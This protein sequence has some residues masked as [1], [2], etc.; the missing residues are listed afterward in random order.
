MDDHE[1][2]RVGV[3]GDILNSNGELAVADTGLGPLDE[4]PG[5]AWEFIK[6]RDNIL[7]SEHIRGYDALL[8]VGRR[9][10]RETLR[11]VDR[12]AIVARYGV[13][14]DT[15]DVEACTDSGVLVT[16]TPDGVRRPVASV[17]VGFVLALS[18]DLMWKDRMT[19]EG[20]WSERYDRVG[21]GLRGR[22]LGL[23]GLGNIGSEVARLIKP[24]DMRL[25]AADPYVEPSSA[26]QLNVKLV[27]LD[28]LMTAA[29]FVCI[30]CPLNNSTRGMIDERRLGLLKQTAFLINV[31]RGPIVD[32]S[33]LTQILKNNRIRGAALDVFEQEPI[34]P[35]DELM[36]L[37]NVLLTP[38]TACMTDQCFTGLG[39]SAVSSILQVFDGKIPTHMVNPRVLDHPRMKL[40][41]NE[42]KT[43]ASGA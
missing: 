41:L 5:I 43:R 7:K 13:G 4:A 8:C 39:H 3:T 38:H 35:N 17:A 36:H 30:T 37:E 10:T 18:L 23:V 6:S 34:H 15:V 33:A 24:F 28:D 12:L 26:T 42:Y 22:V 29:D 11:Q 32:Q 9:V 20:R 21:S 2:F 31:A 1:K 40:K 14:L 19:R 27:G 25:I 16:N